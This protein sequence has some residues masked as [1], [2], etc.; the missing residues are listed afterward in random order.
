VA[1]VPAQLPSAVPGFAGRAGELAQLDATLPG[2]ARAGLPAPA[3][4]VI[5]AVSGTAGA[6]NRYGEATS[7]AYLGDIYQAAGAAR[8]AWQHALDILDQLDHPDADQVRAKLRP[9]AD[10]PVRAIRRRIAAAR[11]GP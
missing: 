10:P 9:Y 5:S 7:L 3:A 1:P 8:R 4:V 2:T 6:G 11:P